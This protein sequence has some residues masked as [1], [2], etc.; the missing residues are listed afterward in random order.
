MTTIN[1]PPLTFQSED[2]RAFVADT[3]VYLR[4]AGEQA[5]YALLI[6]MADAKRMA[7]AADTGRFQDGLRKMVR[8]ALTALPTQ[9]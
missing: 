4:R 9:H 7:G 8:E 5:A 6:R 3:L 1:I 2:E